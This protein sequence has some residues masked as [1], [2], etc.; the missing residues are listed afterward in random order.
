MNLEDA[1]FISQIIAAIAIVASLIFVGVQLRQSDKTQRAAIHQARTD[2]VMSVFALMAQP[3]VVSLSAKVTHRPESISPEELRILHTL[4][5]MTDLNYEEEL[6][7]HKMGLLDRETLERTQVASSNFF[8]VPAV[9]ALW[10]L[11]A[12]GLDAR[13][14]EEVEKGLIR[15]RPLSPGIDLHQA[16]LKMLGDIDTNAQAPATTG[17]KTPR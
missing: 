10:M 6:W 2:R 9:R 14:V 15:G 17:E 5:G 8:A 11:V 12:S 3:N 4:M 16:W 1:Y 13:H 7:Q